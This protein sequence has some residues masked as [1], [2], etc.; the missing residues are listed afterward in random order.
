MQN[1]ENLKEQARRRGLP[2]WRVADAV[3]VSEWTM[4]RWL[5]KPVTEE[6]YK[7][8]SRAI[9]EAADA[10]EERGQNDG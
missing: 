3:G 1:N 9:D 7:Q 4:T 8:I 6:R 5:R 10:L 2:L